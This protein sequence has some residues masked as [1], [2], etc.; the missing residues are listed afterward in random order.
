M[1]KEGAQRLNSGTRRGF[2][3]QRPE[4]EANGVERRVSPQRPPAGETRSK[5][6]TKR[7]TANPTEMNNEVSIAER[8]RQRNP[9][10]NHEDKKHRRDDAKGRR[11]NEHEKVIYRPLIMVKAK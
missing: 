10:P 11:R 5:Q 8:V 2:I 7:G 3:A 4:S 9:K 6:R 1:L